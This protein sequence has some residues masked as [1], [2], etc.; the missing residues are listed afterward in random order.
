MT[1]E[2][3]TRILIEVDALQRQQKQD[4][5]ELIIDAHSAEMETV[6]FSLT[7]ADREAMRKFS[8]ELRDNWTPLEKYIDASR[9]IET[10]PEVSDPVSQ[11]IRK[12][13]LEFWQERKDLA[14]SLLS[15]EDKAKL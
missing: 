12:K 13:Q 11:E 8:A 15:E 5:A 4:E 14:H 1:L 6:W 3:Y 2:E 9:V 10:Y 7:V